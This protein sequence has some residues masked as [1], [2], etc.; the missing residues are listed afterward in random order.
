MSD[1]IRQEEWI[2]AAKAM[3]EPLPPR[4][5]T[6]RVDIELSKVV[7]R[8]IVMNT[9][10]HRKA[11]GQIV[12]WNKTRDPEDNTPSNHYQDPQKVEALKKLLR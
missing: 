9:P 10:D 11:I 8:K 3:N 7:G 1:D 2:N 4:D 6:P 12:K 5:R